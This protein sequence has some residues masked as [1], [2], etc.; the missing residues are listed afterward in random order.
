MEASLD[1]RRG[2]IADSNKRKQA[3][4]ALRRWHVAIAR[5]AGS[6]SPAAACILTRVCMC[7]LWSSFTWTRLGDTR[8]E[9]IR[10]GARLAARRGAACNSGRRWRSCIGGRLYPLYD[11]KITNASSLAEARRG[12][13]SGRTGS[14]L[15]SRHHIGTQRNRR[16]RTYAED[17]G[18]C[19]ASNETLLS[20]LM[21]A[22]FSCCAATRR[23]L[24]RCGKCVFASTQQHLDKLCLLSSSAFIWLGAL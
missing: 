20:G 10:S 9:R 12:R 11:R 7:S 13:L 22:L 24:Y 2:G 6:V 8:P 1:R 19:R 17:G 5:R 23:A 16:E 4:A 21:V 18:T 3:A 14:S 15:A